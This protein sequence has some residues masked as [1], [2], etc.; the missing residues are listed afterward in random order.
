MERA[1][2]LKR[3]QNMSVSRRVLQIE[4]GRYKTESKM[5]SPRL[6]MSKIRSAIRREK[7]LG[8]K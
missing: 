2:A 4:L 1:I 3:G 7:R 6:R 5:G 8:I